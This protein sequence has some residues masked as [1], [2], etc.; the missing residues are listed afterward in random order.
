MF[1]YNF[2]CSVYKYIIVINV[3]FLFPDKQTH[4]DDVMVH[5]EHVT[6]IENNNGQSVKVEQK[7][8]KGIELY[9]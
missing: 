5:Q 2:K 8:E 1:L 9:K 7:E 6:H 3:F 4:Q